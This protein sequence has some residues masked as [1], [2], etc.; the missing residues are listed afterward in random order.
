MPVHRYNPYFVNSG[1]GR[2]EKTAEECF[3]ELKKDTANYS[4]RLVFAAMDET[5]KL[6][7]CYF[8]RDGVLYSGTTK[9]QPRPHVESVV[10]VS[11]YGRN[12]NLGF[13]KIQPQNRY[14]LWR[15]FNESQ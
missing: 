8:M 15:T 5:T 2:H 1:S 13:V 14:L 6:Y 11:K 3:D 4:E 10:W 12:E 9:V 7:T